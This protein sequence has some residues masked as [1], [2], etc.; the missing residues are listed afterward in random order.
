[1]RGV[2]ITFEGEGHTSLG[3]S[4][5]VGAIVRRYLETLAVPAGGARCS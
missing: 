4:A 3:Q 2:L 5:C 1:M